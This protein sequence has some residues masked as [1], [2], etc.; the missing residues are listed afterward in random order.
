MSSVGGILSL[1]LLE[2]VMVE[3]IIAVIIAIFLW[4]KVIERMGFRGFGLWFITLSIFVPIPNLFTMIYLILVPWPIH[5]EMKRLKEYIAANPP[6]EIDIE[7]DRL[8]G[9]LGMNQMKGKKRK[10]SGNP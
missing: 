4:Y 6:S 3:L 1:C 7:L 9:E 5:K 10:N 2:R 8:R